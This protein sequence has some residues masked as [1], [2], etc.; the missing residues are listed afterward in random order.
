MKSLNTFLVESKNLHLE[1]LE[2]EIFN[3][4]SAGANEAMN[5]IDSLVTMLQGN[6]NRKMNVTVKWD[7]APSLFAGINPE[8]GKFFV[9]TKSLFNKTPKINYTNADIDANHGGGLADKL[10][11]ALKHLPKLGIKGVLQGDMLFT[12][13]DVKTETID[14]QSMYTFT[15]NTITYAVP[16]DRKLGSQIS[17]ANMGI[18]FH[19]TYTGK[20]IADLMANF[21]ADVSSLKKT[22]AVYFDDADYKDVS[23]SA[24]FTKKETE[25]IRRNLAGVRRVLSQ[26]KKLIDDVTKDKTLRDLIKIYTNA[27]VRVGKDR[28]SAEE[29]AGFIA[30]RFDQKIEKLKTDSS[31]QRLTNER[32]K[33]TRFIDSISRGM[34]NL[35]SAQYYLSQAKSVILR[36]LQSLN[37]MPS[38][39]RTDDGYRVTNPEGFVAIDHVG[40]A[41]KLVDRME[42]S[43]ANFT[44][45]KDWTK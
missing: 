11:V 3:R 1:H 8:N 22:N 6:S 44:V 45:S 39:I 23:G 31:K 2:D 20:T 40:K 26:N 25:E 30:S 29:L 42:F 15:P 38:F 43:K 14:G 32:N 18:V 27:N 28:G 9:A 36:K 12:S 19:T 16:V 17:S 4:G 37:T 7:G 35:F 41:V 10:K 33:V 13:D 34:N 5:F 21:G 24:T